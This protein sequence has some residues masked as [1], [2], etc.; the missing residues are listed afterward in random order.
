[1]LQPKG[2]APPVGYSDGI[3]AAGRVITLAGQIGWNPAT[4]MFESDDFGAQTKQALEN[5]ATLLA[6]AGAEPK[7]LV[8]LTWYITSRDEYMDARRAIGRAYQ[9]VL[10]KHYPPMSVVIVAGLLDERA[11]V[12]IEAMAVLP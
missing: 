2:W 4:A 5:I 10:G 12:E 7:H 8:R 1:M 3:I 6:E 9:E 11:K